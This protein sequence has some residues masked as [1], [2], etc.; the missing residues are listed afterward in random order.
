VGDEKGEEEEDHGEECYGG[1]TV[2][3]ED[4]HSG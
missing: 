2:W 1:G 3:R 4:G